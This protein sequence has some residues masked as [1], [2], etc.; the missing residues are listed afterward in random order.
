MSLALWV[1]RRAGSFLQEDPSCPQSSSSASSWWRGS[2]RDPDRGAGPQHYHR[3]T[4]GS[5]VSDTSQGE[6]MTHSASG[7]LPPR[8]AAVAFG[9]LIAAAIVLGVAVGSV[10]KDA[11]EPTRSLVG[12]AAAQLAGL[13]AIV[14][15][16]R[17]YPPLQGGRLGLTRASLRV[18][19]PLVLAAIVAG[20]VLYLL[21]DAALGTPAD[22]SAAKFEG[23]PVGTILA[24]GV[25]LVLVG[26]LVEEVLFRGVIFRALR[27]RFAFWP[28]AL[29]AS[30]SLRWSTSPTPADWRD[31][32]RACSRG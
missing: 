7:A 24:A 15:A 4:P 30:V 8:A 27:S 18:T 9:V 5:V 10:T 31:S 25:L 22:A 11:S 16:V 1:G 23:E 20:E 32:A 17:R 2:D 21:F 14:V 26:P 12:G 19:V 3:R 28:A 13:V 6:G 29:I